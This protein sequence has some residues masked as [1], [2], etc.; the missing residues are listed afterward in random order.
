[1]S[2][3]VLICEHTPADYQG[4]EL[5]EVAYGFDHAC[6]YFVQGFDRNGECVLDKDSLFDGLTGADLVNLLDELDL[7]FD[8]AGLHIY[9]MMEDLPI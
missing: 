7:L 6:G 4:V 5:V 3:Y 2:R 9:G 8:I 1:M